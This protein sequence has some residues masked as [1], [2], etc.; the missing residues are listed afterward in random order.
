MMDPN[1]IAGIFIGAVYPFFFCSMTIKAVGRCAQQ[2]VEEVRRQFRTIVGLMEGKAQPDYARAVDI[3]TRG[4]LK[5]MIA[6]SIITI[7]TPIAIGIFL[8]VAGVMGLLVGAITCGFAV[9]LFMAN[10]GATWDNAKKYIERG[11]LGG[12][13]SDPHKAAV[14]GD[15]VGDPF[16]DTAGPSLNIMIKLL[17]IVSIVF[18]AFIVKFSLF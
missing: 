15:T 3:C 9:A 5:E 4:A 12:K 10:S 17:A 11:Y 14:V 6:P 18:S 16:K 8:G 13:K 2:I 1:L 7:L